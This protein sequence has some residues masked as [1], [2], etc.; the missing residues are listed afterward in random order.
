MIKTLNNFLPKELIQ[1]L[2]LI[3]LTRSV[4]KISQE[5][6]QQLKSKPATKSS[7]SGTK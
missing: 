1:E 7:S 4:T 3:T 2:K 5:L 6:T